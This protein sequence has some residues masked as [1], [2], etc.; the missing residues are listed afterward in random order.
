MARDNESPRGTLIAGLDIGTSK[1]VVVIGELNE[2]GRYD[3]IG[4]GTQESHG[5][6]HGV[7]VDI[8]ATV[9]GIAKAVSEAEQMAGAHIKN[10]FVS[11]TGSHIRSLDSNGIAAIRGKEVQPHDVAQAIETATATP[12]SA[13]DQILHTL[14]QQF[15]VDGQDGIRDPVGMDGHRL[16]VKVHVVLG[17]LSVVQN[18]IKCVR[19]CGLDVVDVVL[20]PIASSHAVLT[21]DEMDAGVCLID[22]GSGTANM[23]VYR[24]GS[25]RHTA[26]I[27]TAGEQITGDIALALRTS[28]QEAEHIKLTKG[29][30]IQKLAEPTDVFEVAGIGDHPPDRV[31]RTTLGAVIRRRLEEIYKHFHK[32]LEQT[33]LDKMLIAGVV[34][35]GGSARI[36]GMCAMG[37]SILHNRVRLGVPRYSGP[38]SPLVCDPRYS[39]VVGLLEYGVR[40]RDRTEAERK[41]FQSILG[42]IRRWLSKNL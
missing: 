42:D 1:I 9:Q 10:V 5:L 22:I 18:L 34:V 14:V 30:A 36:P 26:I 2:E 31:S 39:A 23:A 38:N 11:I 16:E 6:K 3:L 13:D 8:E 40:R 20:Q 32:E 29:L 25:I 33:G 17:R 24:E 28:R 7:V 15:I 35:T 19:R 4:L 27:A 21:E 41:T 12:V 37:E